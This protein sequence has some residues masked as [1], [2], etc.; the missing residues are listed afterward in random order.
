MSENACYSSGKSE[1][2]VSLKDDSKEV[3]D[4]VYEEIN[5]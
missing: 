5:I 3:Q 2:K 4:A 1:V